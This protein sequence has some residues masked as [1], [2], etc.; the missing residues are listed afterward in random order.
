MIIKREYGL[1]HEKG[2]FQYDPNE[3]RLLNFINDK[4]DETSISDNNIFPLFVDR[5]GVLWI[6]TFSHGL[7]K[8]NL[9]KKEFHHF[10]SIPDNNNSLSGNAINSIH[11]PMPGELWVGVDLAGGV[12]RFIFDHDK[13]LQVIHYKHNANN[14]NSIAGN[15]IICLVQ[16]K[17][18]E[19]WAGSADGYMSKIIP[20]KAGNKSHPIIKTYNSSAWTFCIMEDREGNYGAAP[21]VAGFGDMMTELTSLPFIRMIFPI[22]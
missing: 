2:L 17:N 20:E 21:G 22:L 6:G 3:D 15:N 13:V 1:V 16:R 8:L 11:S 4:T 18:G 19:V 7:C 12:N 10:K 14:K 9:Y 5:S